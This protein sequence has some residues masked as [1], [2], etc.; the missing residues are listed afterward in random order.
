MGELLVETKLLVPRT[1]SR[2][3]PRPRLTE[4]VG[5]AS[6][7]A[8]TLLSAPAGFGK[9]TLLSALATSLQQDAR[10]HSVAW[11]S[12]DERDV[13]PRRFWSYVLHAV[14]RV[15]PGGAAAALD[16]LA[17]P[18]GG[19]DDAVVALVNELSVHPGD[20]T[21]VLDDFHLVDG[22]Q[23]S[24]GVAHLL[25]HRPPQLHLVIS[26]RADPALPLSRL[27]ARGQLVELRA[28]DLRFTRDEADAYLNDVHGLALSS[29]DVSSLDDRTEGWIAALQLAAASLRDRDDASAFIAGFAGDDRFVVDY[30]ADEVLD[31]QT[32]EVRRFLLETSV[33]DRLSGPLCDA[34]TGQGGGA[35]TLESLERRNLLIVPLDDRRRWYR[36]HR[37]FADVL[38]SRLFADPSE[39]VAA[40][41]R[42]ASVW[43][44]AEG[45]TDAA[46]RH[47]AAA[48][49]V[50]R[51][52]DMVELAAP[53]L[54]RHRREAVIRRWIDVVP[55][56]VVRVRPVL[57][58]AFVA[59]LMADNQ[60]EG[61][62]R[63]LDDLEAVLAEPP[64]ALVVRDP[65]EAA[66]LPA[67]I[68]TQRAGLALVAGDLSGTVAAAERALALAG[69]DD[70]LTL[71]AA[72]A[73]LGLASW[74]SGDL[75][76]AFE[77]YTAAAL[78][79]EAAGH[80]ADVLGCTVTLVDLA[81]TLGWLDDA[82]I[83]ATR[84]LELAAA[85]GSDE[86]VRGTAD[87]WTAL[88][89]IAWLRGDSG[90]TA[91]LLGRAGG[92]GEAA[93][94]PQQPYRWRV[95]MAD[96]RTAA[97]DRS[98]ADA[99]L[100]E[101]ERLYV[102]DFSPDVRPVA[103]TRARLWARDGNLAAAH[104]WATERGLLP[105]DDVSYAKEYELVTLAR[106]LLAD[107]VATGN[108]GSLA[109]ATLLLERLR[110][111][112]E[113][114]GRAATVIEVAVLSAV[115]LE[116]SGDR[117]RALSSLRQAVAL[118]EPEGWVRPVAD[119]GPAAAGLLHALRRTDGDTGFL[120]RVQAAVD[121]TAATDFHV[122]SLEPGRAPIAPKRPQ[123]VVLGEGAA[124]VEPLS[125]RELDVMRLLGSELDGPGIARQLHVSLST[126][127]THT[128]HIYTK[129]GV[130]NR[131]AAVRRAHQLGL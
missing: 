113:S 19:L 76:T 124:H 7:T 52:A 59:A 71:A 57:A 42:R 82:R 13:D 40:L 99:L 51:A 4:V 112:A 98:G 16:L 115:A 126:V 18:A 48:G 10:G 63:R 120:R 127:R 104:G 94:L 5:R 38:R 78:D 77:A 32:A 73:L 27:R 97:G 53:A 93:G 114:G 75:H 14:E 102:G 79:L 34:V 58:G 60:F 87:M 49:D 74:A 56:D 86:V 6:T 81:V 101:A 107:H 12:L 111:A 85:V 128:Q 69:A 72:R 1:A 61:V 88:A 50:D 33:L 96:L 110:D 103:A 109:D 89:R 36:Y 122:A 22:P 68:A 90:A 3:V 130:N 47:A 117:D 45:E 66:R 105:G 29:T 119:E 125:E 108:P 84:A 31:R 95:A 106:V 2:L 80:V 67:L 100:E 55:A 23:V 17:S 121:A 62:G 25:A 11:V 41:H 26:T 21:V 44:E 35:A 9:T 24:S 20:L 28:G 123:P 91:D 43:F 15:C 118:A 64:Q 116:A 54:R 70:L 65:T 37:L 92:L 30:L 131:R 39:D 83:R 8:L 129:L 46:V